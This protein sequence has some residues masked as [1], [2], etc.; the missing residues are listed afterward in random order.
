M[1]HGGSLRRGTRRTLAADNASWM[2]VLIFAQLGDLVQLFGPLEEVIGLD[3]VLEILTL[4]R[5]SRDGLVAD[6][7]RLLIEAPWN[8]G[9]QR[10]KTQAKTSIEDQHGCF[11]SVEG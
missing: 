5:R 1:S 6:Q 8:C 10:R 2:V 7:R 4:H 11:H 3:E 9:G